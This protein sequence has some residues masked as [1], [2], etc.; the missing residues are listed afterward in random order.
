MG[1]EWSRESVEPWTCLTW[2]RGAQKYEPIDA[3]CQSGSGDS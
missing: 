1:S 3:R 2:S